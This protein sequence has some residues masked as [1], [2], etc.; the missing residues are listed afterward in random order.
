LAGDRKVL[1]GVTLVRVRVVATITGTPGIPQAGP[2][3]VMP[4]WAAARMGADRP[5]PNLMLLVGSVDH[6]KLTAVVRKVLPGAPM[7]TYRSAILG[8]LTNAILPHGAYETFA[9]AAVAAAGFGAVIMLIMLALGARPRELT[10]ARLFTMGLSRRQARRLVIAEALPAILA[11]T[12][13]GAICAWALVPLVG[14]SIDLTPFTGSTDHVPVQANFAVI[15]YL[16]AGLVLLAL[17]TLFA[18]AAM[19]RL[20]GVSRAL[21]VGE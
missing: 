21:R 9:Q 10:L 1:I 16:A 20:R 7:I 15:G 2:F 8:A 11:A 17:V 5:P 12:V 13:G 6:A 3:M 14:P 18:Q 4:A 19:T